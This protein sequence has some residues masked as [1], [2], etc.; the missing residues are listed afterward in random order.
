M[1]SAI[2]SFES[3]KN[4]LRFIPL[5]RALNNPLE[6]GTVGISTESPISCFRLL[7]DLNL[8]YEFALYSKEMKFS[9]RYLSISF[10]I[11]N[12]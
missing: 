6:L 3:L 7:A 2:I 10:S 11:G 12:Y 8:A 1:L 4:S 5:A 9:L